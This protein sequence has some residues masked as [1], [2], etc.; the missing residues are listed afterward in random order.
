MKINRFVALA[1]I[2]LLVVGAM[3]VISASA[4]AQTNTPVAQETET[5]PESESEAALV[6][7]PAI[8]AEAAQQAAETY[9]NAGAA[10][11]VEL[12]DNNGQLVYSVEISGTDVIVDAITG[13]V[14]GTK[15][16]ED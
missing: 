15:V 13:Q 11:E 8:T 9:L 5:A 6:G 10:T 3:G 12:E 7:T 2:A 1:A 16:G 14:V 4:F